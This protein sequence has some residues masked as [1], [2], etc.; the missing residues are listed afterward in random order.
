MHD[1]MFWE[2]EFKT[3][4]YQNI[5]RCLTSNIFESM[6][7]YYRKQLTIQQVLIYFRKAF[8]IT[9]TTLKKSNKDKHY[10]HK[11]L[12]LYLLTKYSKEEFAVIATLKRS[13]KVVKSLFFVSSSAQ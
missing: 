11:L 2:Y 6:E 1:K 7:L 12:V 5:W 13:F 4:E 3:Q 8:G 10:K 9:P